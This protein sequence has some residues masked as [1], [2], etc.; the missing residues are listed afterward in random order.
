MPAMFMCVL[1]LV[2]LYQYKL[3]KIEQ[4]EQK[5]EAEYLK[6]EH[7][8]SLPIKRS[9]NNL[10]YFTISLDTLPFHKDAT[11]RLA[12]IQNTI[13]DLSNK[14]ICNLAGLTNTDLKLKYGANNLETLSSYDENYTLFLRTLAEWSEQLFIEGFE[15]D[16]LLVSQYALQCN[17]DISKT[18][19]TLARIYKKQGNID[20]IYA[21][22]PIA[23]SNSGIIDLKKAIYDVL[24]EI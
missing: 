2:L 18:Y 6:L 17:T 15:E 9:L 1:L 11:G 22:L 8:A 14:K 5:K 10:T 13:T 19:T 7:K 16:A 3:R 21:L 12:T 24:N 23:E 4:E 20:S